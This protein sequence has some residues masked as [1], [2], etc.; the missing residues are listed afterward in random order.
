MPALEKSRTSANPCGTLTIPELEQSKMAVLT[1]WRLC[2]LAE[3]AQ[4]N[5]CLECSYLI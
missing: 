4:K 1:R 3:Q 5:Y 2:I